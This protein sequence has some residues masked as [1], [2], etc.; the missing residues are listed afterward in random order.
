MGED[1]LYY[2]ACEMASALGTMS[3]RM[4]MLG[5]S[6]FSRWFWAQMDEQNWQVALLQ[7]W[8]WPVWQ[9]G[10]ALC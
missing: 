4:E 3:V 7:F 8:K 5:S 1:D 10:Q 2:R 9:M 6:F